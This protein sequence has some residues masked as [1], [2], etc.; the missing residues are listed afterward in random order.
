[1]NQSYQFV[2]IDIS[3]STLEIKTETQNFKLSNDSKGIQKLIESIVTIQS[4]FVVCEATGGYERLLMQHLHEHKIPV[5]RVNPTR[6]RAFA[7]SEGIKAKTD[8]IDAKII[9]Q[10]AQQK[11]LRATPAPDPDRQLLADLMDRRA[12]LSEQLAREKNRI[13]NCPHSIVESIQRISSVLE[14][15]IKLIDQQIREL[16]G[17]N[18]K[19]H[20]LN[21]LLQS[22]CGVGK[23]TSWTLLAYLHE[24][25]HLKRN[26]IVA[27]AGLAPYN[28]DSGS[29]AGKRYIQRGRAKIRKC[30]YMAARTAAQHNPLIRNYVN[31]LM[32]RGKAYHCALVA[33]MRKILIHLHILVKNYQLTLDL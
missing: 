16:I 30:L 10:F 26:Q 4:P 19:I 29:I 7:K 28:R 22:V 2:A 11:Q 23:I 17:S 21:Q 18:L 31:D 15:E 27:L 14:Q 6:I 13:Q 20:K 1:M 12:H 32:L 25:G 33:A 9:L 5:A 24:L 3:K 8:P